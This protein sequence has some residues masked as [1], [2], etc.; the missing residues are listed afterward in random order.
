MAFNPGV[1]SELV[2]LIRDNFGG[3]GIT[4]KDLEKIKVPPAGATVWSLPTILEEDSASNELVGVVIAWRDGRAWW[5]KEFGSEDAK[6]GPP[7][8][9]SND[10]KH[11]IGDPTLFLNDKE[12]ELVQLGKI[13]EKPFRDAEGWICDTCPHAQFGTA[14]KGNGQTCKSKRFMILLMTDNLLPVMLIGPTTSVQH[15]QAY[16]NR[17]T[18]ARKRHWQ[19]LSRFLLSQQTLNARIKYSVINPK[20]VRILTEEENA[21]AKYYYDMMRPLLFEEAAIDAIFSDD[22]GVKQSPDSEQEA[23]TGDA[24][25][26]GD[27][28]YSRI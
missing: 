10:L 14:P 22:E 27:S 16:F 26:T 25:Q 13:N 24:G 15:M 12:Q 11:G 5:D 28:Q 17:L 9:K 2:E 4:L 8:C 21:H 18:G 19:V 7:Q 6:N 1:S 23:G 3:R 20:A